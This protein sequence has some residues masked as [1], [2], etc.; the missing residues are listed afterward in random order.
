MTASLSS[1]VPPTAVY[2]VNPASSALTAAALMLAGVSKSGSPAP[3]PTTSRPC[4]LRAL[5]LAVI[6]SVA[7]GLIVEIRTANFTIGVLLASDP[8]RY[9]PYFASSFW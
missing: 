4:A 8:V 7:E 6:A 2:F 9:L 3:N 5:A 1:S